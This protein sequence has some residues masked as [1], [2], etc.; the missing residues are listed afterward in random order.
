MV[1]SWPI[2]SIVVSNMGSCIMT[3]IMLTWTNALTP[4]KFVGR[5]FNT[6][7]GG[8]GGVVGFGGCKRIKSKIPSYNNYW[9]PP[10]KRKWVKMKFPFQYVGWKLLST[11]PIPFTLQ[12]SFQVFTCHTWKKPYQNYLQD[13]K[14]HWHLLRSGKNR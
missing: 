10:I 4:T 7:H 6:L 12:E 5:V 9:I 8:P 11:K 14:I 2:W 1:A 3:S 13:M